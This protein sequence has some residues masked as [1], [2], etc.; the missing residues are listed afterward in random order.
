M[1]L[2]LYRTLTVAG[3]PLIRLYL[4]YRKA[5]GK[6]DPARFAERLGYPGRARP[7][8]VL[9][10][11]HA[12]SVGESLS[13]LP[14][15]E[16]LLRD[17]PALTVLVSTGT[18]TSARLMAERLPAGAFHQYMPVDC[19][20]YVRRFL[21]H[22]RPDL[23]LW[24]E[25]EFWP[26]M[27]TEL[28]ARAAP[29]VLINGRISPRS[30]KGWRRYASLIRDLLSA[31]SLCLG[32]TEGD[33]ERLKVL[34]ARDARCLG[35]LKFAVAPLPY[36]PHQYETLKAALGERPRWLA[37]STHP[38]EEDIV[39]RVHRDLCRTVPDILTIV[40]PRHPERGRA[41]AA[42]FEQAGLRVARRAAQESPSAQTDVYV[43]DTLGELGLFFRL[44]GIVFMGKSLLP[45]GGQ[46]PLEPARL[47]CAIVQ[48]P[49]TANFAEM[50][51]RL[52]AARAFRE[53]ADETDLADAVRGLLN[54]D[55]LRAH[56]AEAAAAFA[57]SES[58][59]L[60]R[61]ADTLNPYLSA[62]PRDKTHAHA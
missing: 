20:A 33:A 29:M 59:V 53:V 26:N 13:L 44:C 49:H 40:V 55:T 28:K 52:K 43:A 56:L 60:D 30:F 22:W 58:G 62:P 50:T 19:P 6:E 21:D 9:V 45:L 24:A 2:A 34:G 46:N 17:R 37:A 39:A 12:A 38:G 42:V 14:L 61:L 51:E 32:Q 31:F 5:K 16:R 27:I 57:E 54:D 4:A 15:I 1:M 7:E 41:V 23:V 47:D 8:G 3:R 10:W 48:G 35:N 36:D 25:S 11:A 18:V